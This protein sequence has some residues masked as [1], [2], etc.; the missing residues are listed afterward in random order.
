M[1]TADILHSHQL[2]PYPK[3]FLPERWLS[4]LRDKDT[5]LAL[6]KP[7]DKYFVP[8][9]KGSRNCIGMPLA[10]A[11]LYVVV[12]NLVRRFGGEGEMSLWETSE[13]DVVPAVDFF[14]PFGPQN[15]T[16]LKVTLRHE[17][18]KEISEK[19]KNRK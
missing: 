4:E 15:S 13:E 7:E 17:K 12:G 5:G 18:E 8:F 1:T 11:E 3:T 9:G 19:E 16:G 14:G 10:M 6:P 2:Y